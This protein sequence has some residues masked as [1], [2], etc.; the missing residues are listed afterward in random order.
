MTGHICFGKASFEYEALHVSRK[1][2]EI[3]VHPDR[4]V[5]VKAPIG[6]LRDEIETR[7]KK[8]ARW[9]LR[10]IDYFQQF[11]PRTPARLF[12]SGETHRYLGRQYRLKVMRAE[13]DRVRMNR[14]RIIVEIGGEVLPSKVANCMESWYR[15][16]ARQ[17]FQERLECCAQG[18]VRKGH[19]LPR[20]QVKKMRSR[21]GSLSPNATLTL[22][23]SLIQAPRECIDYVIMHE[24]CHLKFDDHGPRFYKYLEKLMPDWERRKRR[25]ELALV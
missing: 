24:L 25:L 17:Y 10:Q 20:L 6:T 16:R 4:R 8:R 11:E 12:V 13:A 3:A 15:T 22:N 18:F 9:V 23:L 5:V 19:A 21:W 7:L 1:T 14:G 2:M